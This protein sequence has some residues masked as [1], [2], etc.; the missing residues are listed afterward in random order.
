[1]LTRILGAWLADHPEVYGSAVTNVVGDVEFYRSWAASLGVAGL[2]PYRDVAIE[3]P[4][5]SLPLIAAPT[6]WTAAGGSYRTGFIVIMVALDALGLAGVMALA[7]RWGGALGPWVW[8]ALVPLLGPIA[9]L[10]LDLLPA[11]ATIWALER[12]AASACFTAGAWL[13]LGTLAKLY[14]ALLVP[15]ASLA[16]RRPARQL[17]G[18]ALVVIVGLVPFIGSLGSLWESVVGYHAG[19]GIQVESTWGVALLVAARAGY[20]T[21]VAYEFGAFHVGA[22]VAPLLKSLAT[23]ASALVLVA[24]TVAIGRRAVPGDTGGTAVGLYAILAGLLVV[25]SVLSPQFLL[26]TIA[27]GAAA[28]ASALPGAGRASLLLAPAAALSQLIYPWLYH[29]LLL[30]EGLA[31]GALAARNGLLAAVSVAAWLALERSRG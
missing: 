4:P 29:R 14:P 22:P 19:R 18:A 5:G 20:P 8:V 26:W 10:R 17:A 31:L 7:R 13:G 12:A 28:A 25:S 16:A 30:G 1:V 15:A 27:L 3:Y 2:A 11:V 23:A 9:Y 24:G 6:W 21:G